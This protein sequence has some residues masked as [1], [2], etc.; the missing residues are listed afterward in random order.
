MT[1][2]MQT[3][4][5]WYPDPENAG[6]Q[7]YWDGSAWAAPVAPSPAPPAS[8]A[9]ARAR[10]KAE[11]AYAKAKRPFYKKK[12]WWLLGA[13]VLVVGIAIAAGSSSSDKKAS[14][15]DGV[16][17]LS[18]N[19]KNPPQADVS[20][21]RCTY[22]ASIKSTTAELKILNH[23]SGRSNYIVDVTFQDSKQ[24]QVG[25]GSGIANNVE[26]GQTAI[27]KAV[28]FASTAP[29]KLTCVVKEVNRFAS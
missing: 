5:G 27:I 4:A 14:Q 11:K 21:N 28:D 9:D 7:R 26:P 3:P 22:D 12:R 20:I 2:Q 19:G 10:A 8:A 18:G 23:S 17:T 29:D 13:V 6:N 24:T 15:N 25:S 16:K 1:N